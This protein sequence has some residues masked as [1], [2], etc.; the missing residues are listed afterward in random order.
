MQAFSGDEVKLL[1]LRPILFLALI[2]L[3]GS[4]QA[5]AQNVQAIQ[6]RDSG[7]MMGLNFYNVFYVDNYIVY[8]SQI[9]FSSSKGIATTNPVTNEIVYED[10][11]IAEGWKSRYFVFHRDSSYGYQYGPDR[12][13]ITPRLAVADIKR[14]VAGSNSFENILSQK[15]DSVL[16][17][18]DSSEM[19]EVYLYPE[20]PDTPAVR[21]VFS[22][23]T[24]LNHLKHS[25]NRSWMPP[26]K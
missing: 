7:F 17:S 11:L 10:S 25:L 8:Q 9:H 20:K 13:Y 23:S 16:R 15:P 6:V 19:S 18:M 22:Y 1:R 24:K 3:I 14:T 5:A 26:K 21:V 2:S 12:L 4:V